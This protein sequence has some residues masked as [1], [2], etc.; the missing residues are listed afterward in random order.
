M[1][2]IGLTGTVGSGKSYA[3]E[4]L[5]GLGASVLKADREGHHLLEKEEVIQAV[6]DLFGKAVV[7][8]DGTLDRRKIGEVVFG[9]P[10]QRKRYDHLI[11]PRLLSRIRDWLKE[12]EDRNR[13]CVVE[14]ALIPEWGIESWFD[15][16]WCIKCSDSTALSRWERE[17]ELYW[18]IRKAQYAP[19][20]K[21]QEAERVI[22]N[23]NSK[24]D[25]RNRIERE[26]RRF[27]GE[28]LR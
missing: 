26:W 7:S 1:P 9:D 21:Q 20:R 19:D 12:H 27:R 22:E 23:E 8:E 15:E 10:V 11:R 4:V 24:E 18:K 28:A 6:V 2:S 17:P 13:V 14:A 16:V 25:F 3:L 5:E